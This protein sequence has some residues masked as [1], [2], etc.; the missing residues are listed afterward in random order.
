MTLFFS[1]LYAAID[2]MNVVPP[3]LSDLTMSDSECKYNLK[4]EFIQ[5]ETNYELKWK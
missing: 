1:L 4:K 2:T 5:M 3:P